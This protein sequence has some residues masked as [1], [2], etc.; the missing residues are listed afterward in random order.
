CPL[1]YLLKSARNNIPLN[2]CLYFLRLLL[3]LERNLLLCLLFSR[4]NFVTESENRVKPIFPDI[5]SRPNTLSPFSIINRPDLAV[6]VPELA[7][8]LSWDQFSLD[9]GYFSGNSHVSINSFTIRL[10]ISSV[11]LH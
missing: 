8:S 3:L 6:S 9:P 7:C 2:F 10:T 4:N 1:K 11:Y 5:L